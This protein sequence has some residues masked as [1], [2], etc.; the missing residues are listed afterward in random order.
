MAGGMMQEKIRRICS[1]YN[2]ELVNVDIMNIDQS[3]RQLQESLNN[4]KEVL[5]STKK[6]FREYLELANK[7]EYAEVSVFKLYK[8]VILKEKAIFTQLNTL[9]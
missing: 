4:T 7:K 2:N 5:R 9:K 6:T 1:S 3:Q 8:L